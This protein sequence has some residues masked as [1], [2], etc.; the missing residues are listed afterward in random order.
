MLE[1]ISEYLTPE[2]TRQTLA[3]LRWAFYVAI[4]VLIL[5]TAFHF[6]PYRVGHRVRLMLFPMLFAAGTVYALIRQA[7]WQLAGYTRPEFVRFMERYNPRPDNAA[8]HLIRGSILDRNGEPL[9]FTKTDGSGVRVYPYDMA[10][11]HA[12]GYRHPKEGLTGM[13]SAADATLSGYRQLL[14]WSDVREAAR[15][16]LR[17]TRQIGTNVTL[18]LDARLQMRA[19]SLLRGRR[20]AAVALDPKTGEVLLLCSSPAFDPNHFD[21]RLNSNPDSPLYNRALRGLY[22]AGSTFKTAIAAL[23][24]ERGAPLR[25]DCPADGYWPPKARRPIR[26]H[27]Y[28]SWEKRGQRWPGF[29]TLDLDT[30]LAKSSNTYFA[31]GGVLCGTEPFNALVERLRINEPVILYSNGVSRLVSN[32]GSVPKLS[33]LSIGQGRLQV[34]PLHMAMIAASLANGGTMMAPHLS[35]DEPPAVLSRPFSARTAARVAAAMRNVVQHGTARQ[36]DLPGRE[37]CGKTGTAQNPGGEDHAWFLCFAPASDPQI[38]VAVIVENAG[39]GSAHALPVAKGIL[40]EFFR[41]R[42]ADAAA[43]NASAQ[44]PP[45][46]AQPPPVP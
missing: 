18:T 26:D 38:A 13:E 12:V 23:M 46:T 41:N 5:R 7:E 20:G 42:E 22:P 9:A 2:H 24:V 1:S 36:I 25:L 43:R 3:V 39:F 29:G 44:R 19:F 40:E 35:A 11:V 8:H 21:R 32:P 4:V 33:Q 37:V 16:A 14:S 28:Y 10:A 17:E 15:T 45:A 31:H 30:A 27:E 34:T 6:A